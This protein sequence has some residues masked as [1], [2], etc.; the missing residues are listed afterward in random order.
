MCPRYLLPTP[1]YP[2]SLCSDA[3]SQSL[4]I[5]CSW[6][7]SSIYLCQPA[8]WCSL[9]LVQKPSPVYQ[10]SLQPNSIFLSSSSLSEGWVFWVH[11][12]GGRGPSQEGLRVLQLFTK[13]WVST[14]SSLAVESWFFFFWSVHTLPLM[15][16]A[17]DCWRWEKIHFRKS[18]SWLY[19]E[20]IVSRISRQCEVLSYFQ[21]C[22]P[23]VPLPFPLFW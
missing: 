14:C 9:K 13:S 8:I 7:S 22:L 4:L 1:L 3:Y 18:V 17:F 2:G 15:T 11:W 21:L 6:S 20:F 5:I 16:F 12:L 10:C 23:E 19:I